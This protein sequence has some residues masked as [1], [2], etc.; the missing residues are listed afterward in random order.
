MLA[1]LE[2]S[3]IPSEQAFNQ[4][5]VEASWVWPLFKENCF[6]N[7]AAMG[8]AQFMFY[9]WFIIFFCHNQ[10]QTSTRPTLNYANCNVYS[11]N[12]VSSGSTKISDYKDTPNSHFAKKI[13]SKP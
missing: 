11:Q 3:S 7:R 10:T 1:Q 6:I 2:T 5:G 8:Q 13:S 9:P 4:M 12:L